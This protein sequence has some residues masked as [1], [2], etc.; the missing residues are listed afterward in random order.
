[1]LSRFRPL[2]PVG[3]FTAVYTGIAGVVT[4]RTSNAEFLLY[5]GVMVIIFAFVAWLH[6]RITLSAAALW[7]LSFWGLAHMAGGL[8]PV[9]LTW[10]IEGNMRVLYSWWIIPRYLKYDQVIHAYGFGVTTWVCWQGLASAVRPMGNLRPRLGVLV[11]CMAAG[12]GFG[13]TNE[14]VEFIAT[15]TVPETNVG[16][17]VN[18]GWDL[19]SNMA[20]CTIAAVLIRVFRRGEVTG[21]GT[22]DG[23]C[24]DHV[25]S[26]P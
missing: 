19:V 7:C 17:Y 18:T 25:V 13:A 5:I 4:T 2:I 26:G 6:A 20:G 14:V 9:P 1:M 10:P 11:L 15:L 23:T 12:M 8:L 16:G 22:E 24:E 3:I 21:E